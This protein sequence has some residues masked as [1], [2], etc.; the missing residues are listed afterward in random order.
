MLAAT[1]VTVNTF[2]QYIRTVIS[3]IIT[4][5]TSRVILANLGVEDYGIYCLVGGVVSFLAFIQND[6][7]RTTQR[8]LSYYQGQG[9][10]QKLVAIFNNS[11]CVQLFISLPLCVILFLLADVVFSELLNIPAHRLEAAR[12][13]YWFMVGCL[14]V[15]MQSSPYLATLISHENI[16]YSSIIQIVDSLLKIPVALSLI[17]M[18]ENKL[19]WYS[20]LSFL[21]VGLNFLCYYIY[22]KH[23]YEECRHFS[24]RTFD[25]RLG[26]EMFSF[27]GWNVYGTACIIGRTQGTAIL[28]NRFFGTVINTSFGIGEQVLGQIGFLSNS[29]TTA[30]NPQIIKAEGGGDRQKMFRL[31][32]ISCKFSF[33][34]MSIITV[35]IVIYMP[36]V[37]ELW[38]KEVPQ[39]TAMFCV[40]IILSYQIDQ[41]TMNLATANQA[42]GNV[43][44]YSICVNT[45]KVLTLPVMYLVLKRGGR[46][47]D[48]MIVYFVFETVCMVSRLI[49]LHININL[50]ITKYMQNV[51]LMILPPVIANVVVCYSFS[52][53]L[54]GWFF[55]LVGCIS[56]AVTCSMTYLCGLKNDERTI[57][58]NMMIKAVKRIKCESYEQTI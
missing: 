57:L 23:K 52:L 6:L 54:S 25:K 19:E 58:N 39:H 50:S 3:V 18:S 10:R 21:I 53:F 27:M 24:F 44:V 47:V 1:R 29:L 37:L 30:I 7:S 8:Y 32:E 15:N 35:P 17:L 26:K 20:L 4:L 41:L 9:N 55:I 56:L 48:A 38:L 42:I 22:C 12:W 34:L 43:K 31:T 36:T 40:A 45:I 16:I 28:L 49:F 5:Y 46:P 11:V 33:L 14:F 51:F 13:V 2:I